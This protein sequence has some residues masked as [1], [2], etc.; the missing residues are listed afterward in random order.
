MNADSPIQDVVP[1]SSGLPQHD[2]LLQSSRDGFL[3]AIDCRAE[4]GFVFSITTANGHIF[5]QKP[6]FVTILLG[7]SATEDIICHLS[8]VLCIHMC[9]CLSY[10]YLFCMV[11]FYENSSK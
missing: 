2:V 10:F 9:M 6:F 4:K 8:L 11:P 5:G 7:K 3:D 1:L